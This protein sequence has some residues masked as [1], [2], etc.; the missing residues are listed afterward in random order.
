MAPYSWHDG[1]DPGRLVSWTVR[2]ALWRIL[3][4]LLLP[5]LWVSATLLYL[6]FFA[7]G[8][9]LWQEIVVGVVSVLTLFAAMAVVWVSFGFRLAHRWVDW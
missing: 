3:A 9:D 7:H 4:S 6:G 5:V 2:G 8:F 1:D